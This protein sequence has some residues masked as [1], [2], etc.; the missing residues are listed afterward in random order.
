MRRAFVISLLVHVLLF[1]LLSDWHPFNVGIAVK[2]ADQGQIKARIRLTEPRGRSLQGDRLAI[3]GL[4]RNRP[5][6]VQQPSASRSVPI[7]KSVPRQD[8]SSRRMS[9]EQATE[10]VVVIEGSLPPD[11]E[12]EY[13]LAI[14]RE[15]RKAG[16]LVGVLGSTG[17][18]GVVLLHITHVRGGSVPSVSVAHSSGDQDLDRLVL[19][20]VGAVLAKM[21]MPATAMGLNF[22]LSLVVECGGGGE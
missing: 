18:A 6:L 7:S 3:S 17:L 16:S 19:K 1:G 13:R 11:V 20:S 9:P 4:T 5:Q 22:R 2:Q 14:A 8:A 10:K 12:S 15:L 21:T